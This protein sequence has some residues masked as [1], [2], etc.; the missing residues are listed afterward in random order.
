MDCFL[1]FMHCLPPQLT[2][3]S[4]A[5]AD[6]YLTTID[7]TR[8]QQSTAECYGKR[9]PESGFRMYGWSNVTPAMICVTEYELIQTASNL[10]LQSSIYTS[11]L[12]ISIIRLSG[13]N[14]NLPD[15]ARLRN[16]LLKE[17][18]ACRLH[19]LLAAFAPSLA[20]R[21]YPIMANPQVHF[22]PT[23]GCAKKKQDASS[24]SSFPTPITKSDHVT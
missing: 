19:G 16:S 21:N 12:E 4:P 3:S 18:L 11:W 7:A 13:S 17:N 1:Q 22:S 6:I 24:S 20:H 9:R 10:L 5:A 14:I 23:R 15:L 2:W 8:I